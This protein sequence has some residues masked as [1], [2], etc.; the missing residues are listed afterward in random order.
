MLNGRIK[1]VSGSI[2]MLVSGMEGRVV[3]EGGTL[4]D[5]NEPGELHVRGS[6]ISPGYWRNEAATKAAYVDGWLRTGD[7]IRIDSDGVLLYVFVYSIR[8]YLNSSVHHA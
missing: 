3:R 6:S 8:R 4:A 5:V 1:S 7:R 2:G